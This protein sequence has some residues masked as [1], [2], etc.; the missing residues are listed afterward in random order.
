MVMSI[1]LANFID[2]AQAILALERESQIIGLAPSLPPLFYQF[3]PKTIG[4]IYTLVSCPV[5]NMNVLV[6]L[7]FELSREQRISGG[8]YTFAPPI[9][10]FRPNFW[11]LDRGYY[12][13]LGATT[14]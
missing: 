3:A 13:W 11:K 12:F 8:V 14:L 5:T 6:Q 2:L 9:E 4:I 7:L 10:T 1:F